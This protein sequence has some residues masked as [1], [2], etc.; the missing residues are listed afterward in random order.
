MA[1]FNIFSQYSSGGRQELFQVLSQ[2]LP[3]ETGKP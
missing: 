2:Y 3:R 1:Y